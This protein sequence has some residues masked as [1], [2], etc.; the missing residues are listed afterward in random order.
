MLNIGID[1]VVLCV[2]KITTI[3]TFLSYCLDFEIFSLFF[4]FAAASEMKYEMSYEMKTGTAQS[5]RS[6]RRI[7]V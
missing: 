3:V 7:N 4:V 5:C 2:E 6:A 1:R